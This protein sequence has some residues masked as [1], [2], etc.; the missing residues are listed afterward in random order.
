MTSLALDKPARPTGLHISTDTVLIDTAAGLKNQV[1]LCHQQLLQQQPYLAPFPH[2]CMQQTVQQ[3]MHPIELLSRLV[4]SCH[5]ILIN[6]VAG[7]WPSLLLAAQVDAAGWFD[8]APASP[9]ASSPT[10]HDALRVK[11]GGRPFSATAGFGACCSP[12]SKASPCASPKHA[13]AATVLRS[14]QRTS[15]FD[16]RPYE[17]MLVSNNF[18][19]HFASGGCHCMSC[20]LPALEK[21]SR[22][23]AV[24]KPS[25]Y[26]PNSQSNPNV[27]HSC[28]QFSRNAC[29]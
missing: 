18:Q 15:A 5:H 26:M 1:R 20:L 10:G 25:P 14:L 4:H 19:V 29:S 11:V 8:C 7:C 6:L 23:V 2:E 17:G 16:P 12:Q 22:R 24:V 9:L 21:C 13:A 28:R 3:T 27:L